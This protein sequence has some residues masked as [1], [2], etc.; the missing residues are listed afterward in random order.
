MDT[1]KAPENACVRC[2]TTQKVRSIAILKPG[3]HISIVGKICRVNCF[4][5]RHALYRHHTIVVDVVQPRTLKVIG[6]EDCA[7]QC[8]CNCRKGLNI[9]ERRMYNVNPVK[10]RMQVVS[11]RDDTQ[12]PDKRIEF[13]RE[14]LKQKIRYNMLINNCEH[15]C[16]TVCTGK[17][18]SRQVERIVQWMCLLPRTC[19]TSLNIF[20]RLFIVFVL[21]SNGYVAR[22]GLD[23]RVPW[24]IAVA[25]VLVYCVNAVCRYQGIRVAGTG[26]L[27]RRLKPVEICSRCRRLFDRD[28]AIYKLGVLILFQLIQ[29]KMAER[30]K[31]NDDTLALAFP[32]LWSLFFLI[33]CEFFLLMMHCVPWTFKKLRQRG[34]FCNV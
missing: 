1:N 5:F 20:L 13:A 24:L 23:S 10:E 28:L 21:S 2:I 26:Y 17:R 16:H 14:M 9:R 34:I 4:G 19:L 3:D 11:Y 22:T 8:S 7:H 30:L 25:I 6:F 29:I 15:F 27:I 33:I 31:G 18:T 12:P 32:L